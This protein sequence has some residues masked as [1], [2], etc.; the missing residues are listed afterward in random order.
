MEEAAMRRALSAGLLFAL[1]A[2]PAVA[3]ISPGVDHLEDR[4]IHWVGPQTRALQQQVY[5]QVDRAHTH[6]IVMT[7]APMKT[8]DCRMTGA[9]LVINHDGTG[10]F[11]A[12]TLTTAA[13]ADATWHTLISIFDAEDRPLFSTGDFAGPEMKD[14]KSSTPYVW[15]NRFT[16]D[17][18]VARVVFGRIDHARI[19][20][21]C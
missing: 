11:D 5:E 9:M 6:P 4:I 1:A 7:F 12:T 2:A 10:Q 20:Y 13:H 19:S 16:M 21:L 17:P 3:Q 8:A 18:A 14:G 15:T